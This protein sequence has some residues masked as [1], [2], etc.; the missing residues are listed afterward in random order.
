MP[1]I[2]KKELL[3][4]GAVIRRLAHATDAQL[5]DTEWLKGAIIEP[6]AI[7]LASG[8]RKT[9]REQQWEAQRLRKRASDDKS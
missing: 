4:V 5:L 1:Y 7:V 9:T 3:L 8:D 6:L 2:N